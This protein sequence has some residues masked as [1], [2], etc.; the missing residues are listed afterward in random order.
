MHQLQAEGIGKRF[1]RRVLFRKL[2]FTATPG[3]T[4]AITGSNGSG[5]STLVR[6]LAGVMKP[7]RGKVTLTVHG[8]AVDEE[9][10][11]MHMGVVAPYLNLYDAFTPRENLRFVARARRINGYTERISKVL[12]DV[13]LAARSD[14]PVGTFSSGMKQR[15]RFAFALFS[16]PAVLLLDEPTANLDSSG[17]QMVEHLIARAARSGQI[18]IIA[19]NDRLEAEACDEILCVED[20]L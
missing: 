1:G 20:F 14:D 4:M 16:E 17:V 7:T 18:V 6:I 11:P 15:M 2:S 3:R 19:T 12:D 9:R 13:H 10:R 5:K 8:A